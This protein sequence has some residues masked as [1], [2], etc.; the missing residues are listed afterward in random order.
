ME[1]QSLEDHKGVLSQAGLTLCNAYDLTGDV[2]A[3]IRRGLYNSINMLA[4]IRTLKEPWRGQRLAA[5]FRELETLSRLYCSLENGD[6]AA[7]GILALK[8]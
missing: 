6:V 5:Y 2:A 3:A 4:N 7:A 8:P 1:L